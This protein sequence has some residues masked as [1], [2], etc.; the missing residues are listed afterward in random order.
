MKT[1][2]LSW[3]YVA[4]SVGHCLS[5]TGA[6]KGRVM[7]EHG[8]VPFANVAISGTALGSA[9]DSSG[10]FLLR[11]VPFGH[12]QLTVSAMG[13]QPLTVKVEVRSGETVQLGLLRLM[14]SVLGLDE[15]VVTATMQET[16]VSAS[17]VKV[18]V[19]T[20]RLLERTGSPR[21]VVEA[22]SLINGVT[23]TVSCG[24]CFT[25]SISLNGM[26]GPY[27]AILI[28]G[29]PMYGSLASVYG[30]NGIAASTIDRIEVIKGPA[31]TL[32]GSEAVAGVINVITKDPK[33]APRLTIDMM[34][35]THAEL[36]P[37]ISYAP[38]VGRWSG[39]ISI[40]GVHIGEKED[41]NSDGFNDMVNL[42]RWGLFSKW[43]LQ[44]PD[45]R[46]LSLLGKYLYED[47]RNGTMQFVEGRS[48]RQLRGNDS[49]YGESIYT[50]R[51]EVLATYDL[52]TAERIGIDMAASYHH[53]D[54]YYGNVGYSA[55]QI[56]GYLNARWMRTFGRHSLLAG[57]SLRY[58]HYDD[59]TVGTPEVRNT[60]IPGIYIQDEW[61]IKAKLLT[62]LGGMR[63]DYHS[64]HGIIPAPRLSL[65]VMAAKWTTLR[66]N[67]GTGFRVVN[68]FT[69]DHAF[70]TGQR[71]VVV[72]DELNPERS[73]NA[74][75]SITQVFNIGNSQGN[76]DVTG[77]GTWF[78]DRI[79]PDYSQQGKIIYANVN[80]YGLNYGASVN[81]NHQFRFPLSYT[82]GANYQRATIAQVD[83]AGQTSTHDIEFAP[84]WGGVA[85][86]SYSVKKWNL[87]LAYTVNVTGQMA[88]PAVYDLGPD[89]QPLPDP[90]PTQSQ[91]FA[92]HNVQV[93]KRITR[94]GLRVYAGIQ[95]LG[96]EFQAW[97][98]ISGQNDPSTAPGFSPHF[99]TAYAYGRLQGREFYVGL[100]WEWR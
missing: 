13:Y 60:F 100:K 91:P 78:A 32:Y 51:G 97:S 34:G 29:M 1:V 42:D 48:Y 59:S 92:T 33:Q 30:L 25:N 89:G 21:T 94:F 81:I 61:E 62:V 88:L 77:F 71:E 58:D 95:N 4:L 68:L 56:T 52:P 54:S 16:F 41:R 55:T 40:D 74:S 87:D 46:R 5:Q 19:V 17:P 6:I 20:H 28:D 82:I 35:T 79:V 26:P 11:D 37:S 73:Y 64:A 18:D 84:I 66:L 15:V 39:L 47:R 45:G 22:I 67:M 85:T 83:A 10:N 63:L 23:E 50:H 36:F 80:G 69:E 7:D 2:L 93:S 86:V 14:E 3:L 96:D 65:K 44:R 57:I 90:R 99:D 24:V 98:P 12:Y 31:S 49:I 9:A 38:R 27:T 75:L 76:L 72:S 53:Q 70:I 8:P 43:N